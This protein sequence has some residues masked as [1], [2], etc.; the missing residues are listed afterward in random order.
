MPTENKI[1]AAFTQRYERIMDGEEKLDTVAKLKEFWLFAIEQGKPQRELRED[2]A[3]LVEEASWKADI[4]RVGRSVLGMG[5]K[6]VTDVMTAFDMWQTYKC[7]DESPFPDLTNEE[8][9]DEQWQMLEEEIARI[10]TN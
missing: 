9:I 10:K 5:A 7:I 4:I 8:Y 2:I 1:P 3:M 6:D